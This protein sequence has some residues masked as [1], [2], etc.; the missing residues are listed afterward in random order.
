MAILNK[1]TEK[2]AEASETKSEIRYEVSK[3]RNVLMYPRIS[4][5]SGQ[6]STKLN[7]YVFK[8]TGPANKV[9][10]KKAVEKIYSVNVVSVNMITVKGKSRN[11]G[12][13]KG[14]TSGFKK[15]IVTL[16]EGQK[17]DSAKE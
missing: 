17:I 7:K 10:V 15:A 14:T 9:E 1:K 3:G 4:E 13:T 5:K 12:K 11:F 8:I 16:K 6:L 2:A